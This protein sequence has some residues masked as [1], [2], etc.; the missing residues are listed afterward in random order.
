MKKMTKSS[1]DKLLPKQ[2]DFINHYLHTRSL[3]RAYRLA[4]YS[5]KREHEE[6]SKLFKRLKTEIEEFMKEQDEHRVAQAREVLWFY[7][8]GLRGKLKKQALLPSG[9][10]VEIEMEPSER[11]EFAKMLGKFYGID[12]HTP[13]NDAMEKVKMLV[14]TVQDYIMTLPNYVETDKEENEE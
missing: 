1:F 2:K 13:N 3:T 9:K 12:K 7:T 4:G 11:L 14:D 6:A 8:D 10:I 5:S